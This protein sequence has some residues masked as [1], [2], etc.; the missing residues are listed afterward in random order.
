MSHYTYSQKKKKKKKKKKNNNN[1]RY[2]SNVLVFLTIGHEENR[3][4]S[5]GS[6]TKSFGIVYTES[7]PF[8]SESVICL[9]NSL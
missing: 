1:S 8:R 3:S 4:E 6:K 9:I 7:K 5:E 2:I